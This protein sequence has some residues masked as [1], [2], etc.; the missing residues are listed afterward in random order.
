V[1]TLAKILARSSVVLSSF[2]ATLFRANSSPNA[3]LRAFAVCS[4][5]LHPPKPTLILFG[6]MHLMQNDFIWQIGVLITLVGFVLGVV[7]HVSGS[8]RAS[9][10]THIFYN[11]LQFVAWLA[12]GGH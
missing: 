9:A 2:G 7:R 3:S 5:S 10:I 12:S 1:L 11:A 8:T 6:G 4:R